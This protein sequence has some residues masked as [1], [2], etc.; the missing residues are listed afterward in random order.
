M[1]NENMHY[2]LFSRMFYKL[3]IIKNFVFSGVLNGCF[4]IVIY[5]VYLRTPTFVFFFVS[6]LSPFCRLKNIMLHYF[7]WSL[8]ICFY[9]ATVA[10]GNQGFLTKEITF[11]KE[12]SKKKK[13]PYQKMRLL[14]LFNLSLTCPK[15]KN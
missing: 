7:R 1:P 15:N 6:H 14:C 4:I 11:F 2:D 13:K 5:T 10:V 12:K 3:W 8:E 9:V